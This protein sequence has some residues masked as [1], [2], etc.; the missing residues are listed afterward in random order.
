MKIY[1]MT[2]TFGKLSHQTLTLKPGLNIIEA[3]NEWGKST[4]CAFLIAMLYGIDTST[5]SKKD[6]LAEKERYQPWS[7]EP[8][9][10]RMDLCWNGRDITIERRTKGRSVF[11]QF[12]AYETATGITVPELTADNCGQLLLGV[13]QSVFARAGFLRLKDLPVQQDEVLRRRLNAL[14]TT[15]DESDSADTLAQKL[16]ELK[17]RCRFNRTGLIPQAE[18]QKR[19]LTE[20][21]SQIESLQQQA[22][23]LHGRQEELKE[24]KLALEN[25]RQHLQYAAAR[26]YAGKVDNAKFQLQLAADHAEKLTAV[27]EKI[28][29]EGMLQQRM[30]RL[31]KLKEQK[32][33]LQLE[34]Q[35]Q[36]NAPQVPEALP[37][38]RGKDPD[39][40]VAAAR[41][42][43]AD[44]EALLRNVKTP[45]PVLMAVGV[46]I[47]ALG[48]VLVFA[49][50]MIPGIAVAAAGLVLM[51]TGLALSSSQN[52]KNTDAKA[53]AEQIA[54]SYYPLEAVHWV[55]EA[56]NYARTQ[57]AYAAALEQFRGGISGLEGR[58][59]QLQQEQEALT[60]GN[61]LAAFEQQI[62]QQ[63]QTRRD[64]ADA[65]RER[66]R[67]EELVA[68][69]TSAGQ[70]I[71]RPE[72]PDTLTL[73]LPETERQLSD[74]QLALRE[75]ENR[76]ARNRG[77]M[78]S[79]GSPEELHRQLEQ[80]E[81]RLIRLEKVYA[82]AELAQATLLEAKLELQRRFAPR[83]AKRAQELF[84]RM[85]QGRYDRL[86]LQED[87][88]LLAAAE[89][90]D[91]L[92]NVLWRSEGTADQLYLA[93]RLAVA[94][95]LTPDAPLV[96]DDALVR[97]DDERLETALQILSEAA[98]KK[99]VILFTCQ[100]REG[101]LQ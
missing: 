97:F 65:L 11:G 90:E 55:S 71:E 80:V 101:K 23:S 94:E 79:L 12:S 32:E 66:S 21:L 38:F 22:E 88:S 7:G 16:K 29:E 30:T 53:K 2:A 83:I 50:L 19:E 31:Q 6:F 1:S 98:Q 48:A 62:L 75:G 60:G 92:H 37:Q 89:G 51:I 15:G 5:R 8:M 64:Y 3:P 68:T 25:H 54:R 28:P 27:C 82:A 10:G 85:T 57:Q 9:S 56:E 4:W 99:Q 47:M 34:M 70:Q 39:T 63:R 78:E 18:G 40:V 67:L 81:E 87:L 24:K 20:K 13:E 96:L 44:Y 46:G 100:S 84:C 61:S 73:S 77:F 69:M 17:N 52:R 91:T 72:Q 58:L 74:V 36:P 14:V 93:L 49:G 33:A 95:E 41:Q 45:S 76:L 42:A 86:S 43:A 35:M 59:R 26:D